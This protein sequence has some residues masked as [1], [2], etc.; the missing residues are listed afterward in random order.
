[1]RRGLGIEIGQGLRRL[2]QGLAAHG[3]HALRIDAG[4]AVGNAEHQRQG[5]LASRHAL[6]R[7]AIGPAGPD[8]QRVAPGQPRRPGIAKAIGGAG[9]EGDVRRIAGQAGR[10]AATRMWRTAQNAD[11]LLGRFRAE[12]PVP[13]GLPRLVLEPAQ[14]PRHAAIA[15]RCIEYRHLAQGQTGPAQRYGQAAVLAG[16]A[17]S[18][19]ARPGKGQHGVETPRTDAIQRR[20]R[21]HVERMLQ[22]FGDGHI[23]AETAVEIVRLITRE[24]ARQI[25]DTRPAGGQAIIEGHAVDEGFQRRAGRTCTVRQIDP[26]TRPRATR[27]ACQ[28]PDSAGLGLYQNGRELDIRRCLGSSQREFV[29]QHALQVQIERRDQI[30]GIRPRLVQGLGGMPGL[31]GKSAASRCRIIGRRLR[32]I[33]SRQPQPRQPVQHTAARRDRCIGPQIRTPRLRRLRQG[34]Q[35]G[36]LLDGQ[37]IRLAPEIGPAGCP[38]A[39]KIAAIGRQGEIGFQNFP[40]GI[41]QLQLQRPGDLEQL[42]AE[43]PFARFQKA[44]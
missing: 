25:G 33:P 44:R 12:H 32:R 37:G 27:R 5:A 22:G 34:D 18:L 40:L 35:Q 29:L 41:A 30:A 28:C 43:G 23:T 14:R 24:A 6:A 16:R 38:H 2:R 36:D 19:R 17:R 3:L 11:D 4:D 21:R 9:L 10:H 20:H 42:G 1:M 39:F 26:A 31:G 15:Q 7:R 8:H 13:A